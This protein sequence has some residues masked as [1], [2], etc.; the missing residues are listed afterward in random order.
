MRHDALFGASDSFGLG[1]GAASGASSADCSTRTPPRTL[2]TVAG[3]SGLYSGALIAA[4]HFPESAR[5]VL[6]QS[7]PPMTNR[8]FNIRLK[9]PARRRGQTIKFENGHSP[10]DYVTIATTSYFV[11]WKENKISSPVRLFTC[12]QWKADLA[13]SKDRAVS[14][15]QAHSPEGCRYRPSSGLR[16]KIRM[17]LSFMAGLQSH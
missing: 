13:L 4:V 10:N 14:R 1:P 12:V 15:L 6:T 7:S 2:R 9:N 8:L 3:V 17:S 5:D 16:S 11:L